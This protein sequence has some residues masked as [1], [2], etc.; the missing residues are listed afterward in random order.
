MAAQAISQGSLRA[1]FEGTPSANP[2]LQCVQIKAMENK[3]GEGERYRIVLSDISNFIQTMMATQSNHIVTDG[4]LKKGSIVR[5][6]GYNPQIVKGKKILIILDLEVLEEYGEVDKIGEPVAL[7]P[8]PGEQVEAKAQPSAI[9]GTNFYGN[10][11][12]QPPVQQQQQPQRSLPSHPSGPAAGGNTNLYPI[13]ALSPYAHKW[14]IKARCTHKSDIKHWHK[15]TGEGKLFSVNLLD[16]SGEIKATGFNE[17]CDAL[18]DVFQEGGVYFISSPCRVNLAKK[19]FSNLNNDYEL[20]FERDTAVEKAQEQSDV[21]QVRFNFTSIGDLESVEK[22]TTIDT[23]GVLKDVG[24]VSEI[25]S[26]TTNKPYNKREITLVDNSLRS[27]RMTLWNQ[28]AIQF[29]VPLESVIAFKGVKVSDFG[30]RSLSLLASGTMKVDPD[31]DEAHK[32][33]GWYD[34]QGRQDNFQ[35]HAST[36]GAGSGGNR[37]EYK[38]IAQVAEEGIGMNSEKAEYFNLKATVLYVRSENFA[39]PACSSG[40]CN[41]KVVEV[42]ENE[43]RCEKCDKSFPKPNY[44]YV[45][46]FN[47]SDHTGQMWLSGFDDAGRLIMGMDANELME[48]KNE[49]E[50]KVAELLQDATCKTYNFSVRARMD[51]YNDQQRVR[52]Q[53][54]TASSL[55]FPRECSRLADI[56]KQYNLNSDSLFVN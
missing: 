44:R 28:S 46:S 35:S 21:P 8:K 3:S 47:V 42:E 5:L 12:A 33:K 38:T 25:V 50:S 41:K 10:K 52:H 43:W 29:E 11:P 1:I 20:S 54:Q 13:E 30:G 45:L 49:D 39:Y 14:T 31:I 37:N 34:A 36:M 16:D 51:T 19:Q 4:G 2:I 9:S 22:E 53:V 26:K 15:K 32:L 23:I 24:E 55:D 7:D 6:T 48:I 17:Q 18:Y 27:V 56:L 40:D